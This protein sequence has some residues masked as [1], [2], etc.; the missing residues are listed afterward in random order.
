LSVSKVEDQRGCAALIDIWIY[1]P[2]KIAHGFLHARTKQDVMRD[3][4]IM[5]VLNADAL[6]QWVA[7]GKGEREQKEVESTT[8]YQW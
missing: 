5:R 6:K 2:E 4:L 7:K 8:Y 1:P 3:W